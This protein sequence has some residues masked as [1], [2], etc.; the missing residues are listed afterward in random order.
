MKSEE[1]IR[2]VSQDPSKLDRKV[3][4]R[5]EVISGSLDDRWW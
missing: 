2:V 5:V 3:H 4:E 1:A